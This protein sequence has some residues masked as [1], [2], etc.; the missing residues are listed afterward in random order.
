[1]VYFRFFVTEFCVFSFLGG[2]VFGW[3]FN[4]GALGEFVSLNLVEIM[5]ILF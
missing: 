2:R 3:C 1:M 4:L 5:V